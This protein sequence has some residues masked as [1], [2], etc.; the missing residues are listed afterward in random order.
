MK[1]DHADLRRLALHHQFYRFNGCA[2]KS[3]VLDVIKTLSY[4]QIDTISVIAR[5]HHHTLFNRV[6]DYRSEWLDELLAVDR[7]IWEHWGH[8]ASYFTAG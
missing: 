3:A 1:I 4:I 8:A 6:Y 5:A 7:A 2:G